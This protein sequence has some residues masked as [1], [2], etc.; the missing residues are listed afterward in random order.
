MP[1]VRKFVPYDDLEKDIDGKVKHLQD[2][3]ILLKPSGL[4]C[5]EFWDLVKIE[6]ARIE[7]ESKGIQNENLED[8][9]MNM[10]FKYLPGYPYF[11]ATD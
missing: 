1:K 2:L 3:D 7:S 9:L 4:N 8:P 6:R 5:K 10:I 11:K